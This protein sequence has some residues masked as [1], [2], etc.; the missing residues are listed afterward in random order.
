MSETKISEEELIERIETV[1][2]EKINPQLLEH[3]GWIELV[4]VFPEERACSVRFRGECS[5]C[6]KIDDTLESVVI[7]EIRKNV[8]EIRHVEIDDDLDPAVWEMAKDLFTH[9]ES[10][11]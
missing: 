8:R 7:P 10:N 5:A 3:R 9:R 4:D 6:Q 2:E 1:I 11:E